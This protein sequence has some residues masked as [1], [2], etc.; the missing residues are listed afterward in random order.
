MWQSDVFKC[1]KNLHDDNNKRE[2][3]MQELENHRFK[4]VDQSER[5][6]SCFNWKFEK[7]ATDDQLAFI[8]NNGRVNNFQRRSPP[9]SPV[10]NSGRLDEKTGQL[11]MDRSPASDWDEIPTDS[12]QSPT[13]SP[14]WTTP[15]NIFASYQHQ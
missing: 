11:D 4:I 9:R 2:A 6:F 5:S 14:W 3:L 13:D 8:K 12:Q 15:K 1:T 7:C 10:Y